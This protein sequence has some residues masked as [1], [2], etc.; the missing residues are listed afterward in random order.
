[1]SPVAGLKLTLKASLPLFCQQSL[2]E[3]GSQGEKSS[4]LSSALLRLA[5]VWASRSDNTCTCL[6]TSC[7]TASACGGLCVPCCCCYVGQ[8]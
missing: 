2:S 6:E 7:T 5:S 1:M 8:L 4:E 3:R